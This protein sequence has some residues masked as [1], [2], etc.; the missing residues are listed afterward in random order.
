MSLSSCIVCNVA[1]EMEKFVCLVLCSVM[2]ICL[3]R[4]LCHLL[5]LYSYIVTVG[6]VVHSVVYEVYMLISTVKQ[7]QISGLLVA[8]AVL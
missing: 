4:K 5:S 2:Q 8:S 7:V 3:V 6:K 1:M